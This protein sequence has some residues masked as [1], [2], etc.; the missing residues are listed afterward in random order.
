MIILWIA[1]LIEVGC[2]A[3]SFLLA[4]QR[5]KSFLAE[6]TGKFQLE[7]MAPASLYIIDRF[8]L[9]DRLHTRMNGAHQKIIMLYGVQKGLQH[10]KLFMAQLLSLIMIVLLLA[11]GLS[12]AAEG[13]LILAVMG[14]LFAVVTPVLMVR[15][16][17]TKIKKRKQE[18]LLELPEFLNK[19]TLLVNAGE[20]VQK[21]IL[22]CVDQAKQP[23]R[24]PLYMELKEVANQLRNNY[25]FAQALEDFS[26][27]CSIQEVSVFTTTVLLNY[28]RGGE[29]F[30]IAL[31]ELSR[32]LWEKR[33]AISRTLGE[34]ASSKLV[35]PMVIIFMVV[36]V[37][38]A[39][40]AIMMMK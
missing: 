32:S 2:I 40:P 35:F 5:Y 29:E 22:H 1:M 8:R 3:A 23:D 38:V 14:L 28:R 24:S 19:V 34:E 37:V 6:Y 7:F 36:M 27:R 33:K 31:Q 11:L 13:E 20:T 10:T 39:A 21:A 16:L 30:V 12:I 25:S 26:K 15:D 4:G 17:D 18:I 9:M